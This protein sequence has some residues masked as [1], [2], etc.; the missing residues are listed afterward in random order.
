MVL[1]PVPLTLLQF[2]GDKPTCYQQFGWPYIRRYRSKPGWICYNT[3]P[4]L[5]PPADCCWMPMSPASP[6]APVNADWTLI[7]ANLP[8]LWCCREVWIQIT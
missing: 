4:I 8:F 6:A 7:P 2:H 1:R 3:Q 5:Y